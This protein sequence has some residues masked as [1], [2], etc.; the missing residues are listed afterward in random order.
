MV[1]TILDVIRVMVLVTSVTSEGR[2]DTEAEDYRR[3]YGADLGHE[4][5]PNRLKTIDEF[6]SIFSCFRH[7][8]HQHDIYI[9]GFF[10]TS[11]GHAET[12]I[13]Q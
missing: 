9:A 2:R 3:T 6:P 8:H 13:G 10:P 4:I 5:H 12:S 7:R 11:P 1:I